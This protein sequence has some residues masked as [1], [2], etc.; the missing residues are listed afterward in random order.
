[1]ATGVGCERS[2]RGQP[3]L[4]SF[5]A[6]SRTHRCRRQCRNSERSRRRRRRDD[7][8]V[9]RRRHACR[10]TAEG[11][12]RRRVG[13]RGRRRRRAQDADAELEEARHEGGDRVLPAL[14]RELARLIDCGRG[15]ARQVK[16]RA[17]RGRE[18]GRT[19]L[20]PR[21]DLGLVARVDAVED[22]RGGAEGERGSRVR[23]SRRGE[24]E[25]ARTLTRNSPRPNIVTACR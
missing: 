9:E 5:E 20:H 12:E 21:Q 3:A 10:R 17:R 2:V 23:A 4:G 14:G 8:R 11:R 18:R 1:M 15:A 19:S 22:L 24:R 16:D 7:G 6:E 25:K 13:V